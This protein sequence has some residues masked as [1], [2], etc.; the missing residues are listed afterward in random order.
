[1]IY[2]I[3]DFIV[4]IIFSFFSHSTLFTLLHDLKKPFNSMYNDLLQLKVL[5]IPEEVKYLIRARVNDV[6]KPMKPY[7]RNFYNFLFFQPRN[8]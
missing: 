3:S 2:L 1:M 6:I 7:E 4:C 8:H 5:R